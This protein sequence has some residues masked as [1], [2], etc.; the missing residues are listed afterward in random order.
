M[1]NHQIARMR[2]HNQLLTQQPFEKPSEVVRCLGAVQAQEYAGAKWAIGLR[3]PKANEDI[4]EQAVT[5]GSILRTHVL[6]PTWHF[7][8]AT[9]I[10]WMLKLTAP[11]AHAFSAYWYRR[12]ELNDAIFRHSEQVIIKAL[13]SGNHLTR[14]ELV[15]PLQD[16]G[17]NTSDLRLTHLL[18]HAELE[19]IVCNGIRR[20]KQST[21]ALL[22]ERVPTSKP[23]T[24]N[25]ALAELT[26]RYFASRG[27]ATLKDFAWWSGLTLADAKLGIEAVKSQLEQEVIEGQT[28]WFAMNASAPIS[29]APSVHLLPA[30]DE[31]IVAYTDRSAVYDEN[32]ANNTTSRGNILFNYIVVLNGKVVGVWK[33]TIKK[34]K[35]I[36]SLNLFNE[37]CTDEAQALNIQ[38]HKYAEFWG[39]SLNLDGDF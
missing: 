21:Y 33:R 38:L 2:L 15:I 28:Y 17:I 7:V 6:R 37:L 39:L 19:G 16:A 10:R 11:R 36:I 31:Y 4:I 29:K 3:M 18:F 27:P 34:Q 9:D 23:Y 20:G 30:Y 5:E 25:E 26:L 22:D 13:E 1:T 35:A 14:E 12:L 32:M 8:S 24:H